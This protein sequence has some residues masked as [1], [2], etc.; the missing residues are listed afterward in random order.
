MIPKDVTVINY[1]CTPTMFVHYLTSYHKL[2]Q[3]LANSLHSITQFD[4]WLQIWRWGRG[5]FPKLLCS[6]P[7]Y[8]QRPSDL[9]VLYSGEQKASLMTVKSTVRNSIKCVFSI[10]DCIHVCC[11]LTTR[12]NGSGIQPRAK[13]RGGRHGWYIQP[14]VNTSSYVL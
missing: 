5:W 10:L 9:V 1:V 7:Y 2:R 11:G 13:G 14:Y 8:K 6:V 3:N 12:R 4:V